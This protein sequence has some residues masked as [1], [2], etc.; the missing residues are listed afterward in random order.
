MTT[1]Q[2]WGSNPLENFFRKKFEIK[3]IPQRSVARI[4]VDTGYELFINGRLVAG[5]DEWSNTRDYDVRIFLK[6]GANLI[7][8]RCMNHSGHRGLAFELAVDGK[9]VVSSDASWVTYPEERWGWMLDDFDDSAWQPAILM[10]MSWAGAPQWSTLPGDRPDKIV[11][12]LDGT[13]FF[14]GG[15][16]K[17]VPSPFFTAERS[18]WKPSAELIEVA[19]E[20]YGRFATQSLPDVIHTGKLY[21]CT[22]CRVEGTRI[23]LT[24]TGRYSGPGFVMDFEGEVVGYLRLRVSS[25]KE[26]SLRIF[27]GESLNEAM[28]EP[29]RDQLLHRMLVEE[30]RLRGG[31]QEFESRMRVG[32]RFA[33]VEFF[34]CASPVSIDGFSLR[35]S[36]YPVFFKGYFECSDERLNR[37]WRAGNKTLH[38]CM[39]EYYLDAIKRDRFLWVGDTRNEALYNYYLFGDTA[40]FEFCWDEVSKCQFPDGGISSAYG[41]G[42][43]IILDY[44]AWYVIA[45]HDYYWHTGK[46]DFLI[47]HRNSIY[48]AVDFLSSK[49]GA[50]GLIDL[51]ENP[52]SGW[53]VVLNQAVG[54]DSLINHLYLRSLQTALETA[55]LSGDKTEADTY[56]EV[57]AAIT[58]KVDELLAVTPLSKHA[59]N[60]HSSLTMPEVI[61]ETFHRGNKCEALSLIRDYFCNMLDGG[62]DTLFE[63]VRGKDFTYPSVSDFS[64]NTPVS[65]GSHCHGWTGSATWLLPTE[66]AGI[67]P[68]SPGFKTFSISPVPCDLK[69]I[70]AVVP[71]PFGEIAI[72]IVTRDKIEFLIRVPQGTEAVF[73]YGN[74]TKNLPGGLHTVSLILPDHRH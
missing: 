15:I 38:L 50:D 62:D 11:P 32:F 19:G 51:P 68:L 4:F 23:C 64:P 60:W 22:D 29:S 13:P 18:D 27:Y 54:K 3:Q 52:L 21:Y 48:R 16:P 46:K 44:V 12:V 43:S 25:E 26:V 57:L 71:T 10:D 58:E 6:Q 73:Q 74:C 70:T 49:A 66:I 69:E 61:L 9:S 45:F 72:R 41:Q 42:M 14:Q 28:T 20:N 1:N 5:I 65:H 36:F 47:R 55:E 40:L 37:L 17:G 35:T 34:D 2:I 33:R 31:V 53:M 56:R 63:G 8:I 24:A 59:R 39:Q 67:R 7:A 30:Y